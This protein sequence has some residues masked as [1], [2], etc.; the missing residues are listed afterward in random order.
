MNKKLLIFGSLLVLLMAILIGATAV[1]YHKKKN[2][3]NPKIIQQDAREA[4]NKGDID[5]SVKLWIESSK[6]AYIPKA[7][8]MAISEKII[9]TPVKSNQEADKALAQVAEILSSSIS[10]NIQDTDLFRKIT[11]LLIRQGKGSNPM[12]WQTLSD[13]CQSILKNKPDHLPSKQYRALALLQQGKWRNATDENIQLNQILNDLDISDSPSNQ[14]REIILSR[15]QTLLI[16]AARAKNDPE[17]SMSL[18]KSALTAAKKLVEQ[19]PDSLKSQIESFKMQ[20]SMRQISPQEIPAKV[21]SLIPLIEKPGVASEELMELGK[22]VIMSSALDTQKDKTIKEYYDKAITLIPDNEGLKVDYSL[23]LLQNQK[24]EES[25][26]L[27]Q[28][29]LKASSP[30]PP[31]QWTARNAMKT[32]AGYSY[33][34]HLIQT[35]GA[36]PDRQKREELLKTLPSILNEISQTLPPGLL[37]LIQSKIAFV[38]GDY[39]KAFNLADQIPPLQGDEENERLLIMAESAINLGIIGE[40]KERYRKIIL[41]QGAGF[42]QKLRFSQLLFYTGEYDILENQLNSFSSDEKNHPAIKELNADYLIKRGKS[43]EALKIYDQLVSETPQNQ[44]IPLLL[45]KAQA[46]NIAQQSTQALATINEALKIDPTN[47]DALRFFFT[48]SNDKASC[49]KVLNE[50]SKNG[51]HP[52]FANLFKTLLARPN[53][54]F[55]RVA[56]STIPGPTPG[57]ESYKQVARIYMTWDDPQQSMSILEQGFAAFPADR[58]LL[59]LQFNQALAKNDKKAV[60]KIIETAREK[61]ADGAQGRYFQAL[62]LA[63]LDQLAEAESVAQ[64]ILAQNQTHTPTYLL[65]AKIELSK[66]Q[67]NN[68]KKYILKTLEID[69]NQPQA[70]SLL[71]DLE[72]RDGNTD[73]ALSL[74]KKALSRDPQNSIY[75][76]QLLN[77]QESGL[78]AQNAIN[79]RKTIL[80]AAPDYAANKESL[81]M[82]LINEGKFQEALDIAEL[83][84]ITEKS[85]F[86]QREFKARLL[87]STG[88]INESLTLFAQLHKEQPANIELLKRYLFTLIIAG[89]IEQAEKLLEK[90]KKSPGGDQAFYNEESLLFETLARQAKTESQSREY[91]L[92]SVLAFEQLLQVEKAAT[93]AN[94]LRLARLKSMASFALSDIE[95]E[96]RRALE[97]DPDFSDATIELSLLQ[98]R[99][100]DDEKAISTLRTLINKSP[101]NKQGWVT[102]LAI[103]QAN[104]QNRNYVKTTDEALRQ[105]PKDP[106]WLTQRMLFYLSNGENLNALKD[107]DAAYQLSDHPNNLINLIQIMIINGQNSQAAALLEKNKSLLDT[108]LP[109]R[110]LDTRIQVSNGNTSGVRE[111]FAQEL[112][113]APDFQ[114]VRFII[115][116]SIP[117]LGLVQTIDLLTKT[118]LKITATQSKL[119]QAE[120]LVRS[121]QNE[122]AFKILSALDDKDITQ[123]FAPISAIAASLDGQVPPAQLTS[124]LD[125]LIKISEPASPALLVMQSRQ[126]ALTGA[127]TRA[128]ELITSSP[129]AESWLM[130]SGLVEIYLIEAASFTDVNTREGVLIQADYLTDNLLKSPVSKIEGLLLKARISLLR[131]RRAEAL[132]YASQA[133]AED[134]SFWGSILMV[135]RLKYDNGEK[136]RLI[137]PLEVY[138]RKFPD[139]IPARHYLAGLMEALNDRK[140]PDFIDES[141]RLLPND[142]IFLTRKAEVEAAKNN[143][144]AAVTNYNLALK[145]S[146]NNPAILNNLAYILSEK[147]GK[148]QEAEPFA[149]AAAQLA[150]EDPYILDTLGR[151]QFLLDKI[152]ES[153]ASLMKS[154]K[155]KPLPD[156]CLHLAEIFI[157]ENNPEKAREYITQARQMAGEDK[158]TLERIKSMEA[159]L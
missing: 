78:N 95:N 96:I 48:L 53:W 57:P 10:G 81:S 137:Q 49:Q 136:D 111:R 37:A 24:T 50:A 108:S 62:H 119:L 75:L 110:L 34:N 20:I 151:V 106:Y 156:N 69:P 140:Y 80:E 2:K 146:P 113:A 85:P 8:A 141:L 56:L 126:L 73:Q 74:I 66:R 46:Q 19:D 87:A 83:D 144:A 54:Q 138:L 159:R 21:K 84:L 135:T 17:R 90:S 132:E 143:F 124:F 61:N 115:N 42:S 6:I 147:M 148:P 33:A 88:K 99:Q 38:Q 60:E 45:K 112:S 79:I 131:E 39:Q 142:T 152:D 117:T 67:Y 76:T 63:A 130:Q 72:F 7:D 149:R 1:I 14:D 71:A 154:F 65:L 158:A 47:F 82:L 31:L 22:M 121:G 4:F 101:S 23:Y 3:I 9:E 127:I 25:S 155:I 150:P 70:I 41:S 16:L 128:K 122:Q 98:H 100:G 68:A 77:F 55:E 134:E 40:A 109:L 58:Q 13:L 18:R 27:L 32:L 157:K 92:K 102:L 43:A 105:F 116:A 104:G 103:Y 120:L 86:P 118:S 29:I 97:L 107:A 44:K 51:L 59:E 36:N 64:G 35:A 5:K 114:A 91:A 28:S 123:Y 125:K 26:A 52:L 15:I 145:F 139:N 94:H 153:K 133:L 11:E 93:P 12:A 89:E 30:L 129:H